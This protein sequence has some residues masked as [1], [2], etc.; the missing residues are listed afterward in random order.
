MVAQRD[1]V[2]VLGTDEEKVMFRTG[3]GCGGVDESDWLIEMIELVLN[4]V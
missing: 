1:H 2:G 4:C 3:C